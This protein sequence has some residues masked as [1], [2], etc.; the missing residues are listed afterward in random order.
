MCEFPNAFRAACIA[1]DAPELLLPLDNGGVKGG[2]EGGGG[3]GGAETGI[4]GADEDGGGGG[5]GACEIVD[6]AAL[7]ADDAGGGGGGGGAE[8]AVSDGFRDAIGRGRG[9]VFPELG[10]GGGARGG[11]S[12]DEEGREAG[13]GG[14][15][16]RLAIKGFGADAS[17]AEGG[18]GGGLAPGGLGGPPKGGLGAALVVALGRVDSESDMYEE[19]LLAPVS[20]PPRLRSFGIPPAKRPPN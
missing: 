19:S 1:I 12:R 2:A 7:P 3:G 20:I 14:G 13:F 17:D 8:G 6:A 16:R 5:G 4:F 10:K 11:I 18:T 15:F 9:G